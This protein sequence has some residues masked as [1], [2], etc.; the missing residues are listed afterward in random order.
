MSKKRPL[1]KCIAFLI[2]VSVILETEV[3]VRNAFGSEHPTT[4]SDKF[5]VDLV[6]IQCAT[7]TQYISKH[8]ISSKEYCSFLDNYSK[9]DN[10]RFIEGELFRSSCKETMNNNGYATSVTWIGANEFSLSKGKNVTLPT[11]EQLSLF[12]KTYPQ[13][14]TKSEWTSN[15]CSL[16]KG[17]ELTSNKRTRILYETTIGEEPATMKSCDNMLYSDDK[18]SFRIVISKDHINE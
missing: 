1:L 8:P 2:V 16:V 11:E 3:Q 4:I 5:T 13:Y 6:E 12:I 7:G 14:A 9:S 10:K 15:S 18:T 17:D